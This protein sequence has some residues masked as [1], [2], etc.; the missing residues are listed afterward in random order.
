MVE[1]T[2]LVTAVLDDL[3]RSGLLKSWSKAM[4]VI[5]GDHAT[6][7]IDVYEITF[8]PQADADDQE[9]LEAFLQQHGQTGH[10]HEV[11]V[12]VLGRGGVLGTFHS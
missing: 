6:R 7:T 8:A 3:L 10:G 5:P 1:G 11:E 9:G 4:R 12:R 2:G